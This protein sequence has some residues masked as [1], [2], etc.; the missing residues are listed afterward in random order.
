MAD[1]N[2][3]VVELLLANNQY[4]A[5]LSESQKAT[6]KFAEGGTGLFDSLSKAMGK[7]GV[8]MLAL[9]GQ[10]A[11]AGAAINQITGFMK[12]ALQEAGE[13]EASHVRLSKLLQING[14]NAGYTAEQM[15]QYASALA[16]TSTFTDDQILAAETMLSK[17]KNIKQENFGKTLESI[18]NV[19]A[20]KGTDD[21]ADVANS[22]GRALE[23]PA[24]ATRVLRSLGIQLTQAQ[25]E[26]I[27]SFIQV[28]DV[29]S[30]QNIILSSLAKYQGQAE[31]AT[32]TYAGKTKI[33]SNNWKEFKEAVGT[34]FLPVAKLALDGINYSVENLTKAVP[35]VTGLYKHVYGVVLYDSIM[36][37]ID[38]I[39]KGIDKKDIWGEFWKHC[40][41]SARKATETASDNGKEYGLNFV[42]AA[43]EEVQKNL[44]NFFEK[45]KP[46]GSA[47]E[48]LEAARKAAEEQN[49]YKNYGIKGGDKYTS[50][51]F[52]SS[53]YDDM[54]KGIEKMKKEE[55]DMRK[56]IARMFD[57][58][59]EGLST[60][61]GTLASIFDQISSNQISA[62]EQTR[63]NVSAI[64]DYIEQRQLQSAGVQEETTQKK[65]QKEIATLQK[66]LSKTMSVKKRQELQENILEKQKENK[67]L[68][69]QEDA[70]K[71]K[72]ALDILVDLFEAQMKRKQFERNKQ[73]QIANVWINTAAAITAAWLAAWSTMILPPLAIAMGAVSTALLLANAVAQTV[74]ITQQQPPAFAQG[75][76]EIPNDTPAIVHAGETILPKPFAE[77]FRA[78]MSGGGGE[79]IHVHL[80]L[81]GNEIHKAV[82]KRDKK[83]ARLAGAVSRMSYA[84]AY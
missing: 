10:T 13:F 82:V 68:K 70:A 33:L 9:G 23:N 66:Q 63:S 32:E 83:Q 7:S 14:Y 49:K 73:Y 58:V 57:T 67:R 15:E 80:N 30:A 27:Q 48:A 42:T 64:F 61:G 55:M 54:M 76:W 78:A 53:A 77:D 65:N 12:D 2:K 46:G 26:Q 81:D 35:N 20:F 84:G 71:R 36:G 72:Q 59:K 5:K 1:N 8:S 44:F 43:N 18:I 79:E 25:Q 29:A 4:L 40:K 69:I 28:N 6:K 39:Q 34:E 17:F 11:I 62:L 31:A 50:D 38:A 16:K 3:V 24:N 47:L 22:L 52:A 45:Y 75:A 21:L 41:E 19:G 60:F 51:F 56:G 74:L 37:T